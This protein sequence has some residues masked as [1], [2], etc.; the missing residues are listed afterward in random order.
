[1]KRIFKP[2]KAF[3]IAFLFVLL[4]IYILNI[5][6]SNLGKIIGYANIIFFGSLI[7]FGIFK[8][9]TQKSN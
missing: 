8:I 3:G 1:M 9:I 2:L 6:S 7:F 4:G 5:S